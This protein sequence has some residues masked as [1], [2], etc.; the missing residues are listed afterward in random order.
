MNIKYIL[1][2]VAL[3]VIGCSSFVLV[4]RP[5]PNVWRQ[6]DLYCW[7]KFT[8]GKWRKNGLKDVCPY[9]THYDPNA[10]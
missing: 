10:P 7:H 8:D 4:N 9:G 2:L 5:D 1:V 6:D 3:L